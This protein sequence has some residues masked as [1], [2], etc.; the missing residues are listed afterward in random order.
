MSHT[1]IRS[2]RRNSTL[3]A[4][5]LAALFA[6]ANPANAQRAPFV[7]AIEFEVRTGGDN[8]RGGNDNAFVAALCGDDMIGR[9]V[10]H[11]RCGGVLR[12]N[13]Q[14]QE[15]KDYTQTLR[16]IELPRRRSLADIRDIVLFVEGFGGGFNGDNWNVDVLRA[17]AIMEGGRRIP[18]FEET[19]LRFTGNN[20][21]FVRR[22]H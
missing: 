6:A 3:V 14:R 17:T 19:G 8:L 12:L 2:L 11:V 18:L 1:L 10:V 4:L 13:A 20:R 15:L 5:L 9:G 7:R 22:I 21:K 16:T